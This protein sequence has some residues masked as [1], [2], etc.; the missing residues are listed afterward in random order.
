MYGKVFA[1]IYDGTLVEHWQALV[2]FQQLIVLADASGVVDMTPTAIHRR[3]GI[4]LEIIE[5]GLRILEAPDQGSRTPDMEGRRIV[6]IDAHRDWGWSLVNHRKYRKLVSH[7]EKREADRVRIAIQ[8]DAEKAKGISSVATCSDLSR[9]VAD[10]AHTE[11]YAEAEAKE[12]LS[13]RSGSSEASPADP[14]AGKKPRTTSSL[15]ERLRIV[16]REAVETFNASTLTKRQGGAL[17]NVS[18]SVGREKRQ[19]QIQRCIRTARAICAESYGGPTVTR[20]FWVDYW[21]E[22]AK[23]DFLAGRR[24]GGPGHENW[25]PDFEYLTR[26][27][28]MLKVYDRA[29]SQDAAA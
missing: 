3:T 13:L 22:I 10:V 15:A 26:E 11:A 19:T 18:P 29:A 5:T 20:E 17:A 4:P 21:A 23:D 6:R 7:E 12:L 14:S 25:L 16:T 1:Q 2:T 27:A 24:A 28:T 9:P 8:R